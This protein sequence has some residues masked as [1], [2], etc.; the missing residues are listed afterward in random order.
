MLPTGEQHVLLSSGRFGETRAIVADLAAGLRSLTVGGEDLVQRYPDSGIAPHAAGLVLVPWPNRIAGAV[1]RLNGEEQKLDVTDL[2]N[3][4]ASHGLLRNT[5][6][7]VTDR[8]DGAVTLSATVHPQ[9]GYPFLLETSVRYELVDDGLTVTHGIVNAG[10]ATAPVA[11]GAHPYLRAGSSRV[12]DLTL[13]VVAATRYDV[14]ERNIP[15]STAPVPG[16]EYDLSSG[17]RVGDLSLDM[18]YTG[19]PLVDGEYRHR[20]AA[21]DGVVTELWAGEDFAWVQAFTKPG[22]PG[23][24]GAEL[25]VAVEPMTAPADAFNSGEGVRWLAPGE[26]WLTTWGIRRVS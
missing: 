3:G 1:W 23:P 5:G 15:T 20:L 18:A 9:H 16:T 25:A 22:F 26:E 21:P 6:Y 8:S 13:T 4:N 14:D 7:R 11:I 10:D 24:D 2:S 17:G 12:E 19:L